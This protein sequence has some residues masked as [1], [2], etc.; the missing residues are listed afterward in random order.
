[1]DLGPPEPEPILD[2]IREKDELLLCFDHYIL[3][4]FVTKVSSIVVHKNGRDNCFKPSA[5]IFYNHGNC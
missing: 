3:G 4:L 1:M 2:V 5:G